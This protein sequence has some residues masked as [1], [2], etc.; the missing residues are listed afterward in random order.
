MGEGVKGSTSADRAS[1]GRGGH[2][3]HGVYSVFYLCDSQCPV[4]T[5]DGMQCWYG[6]ELRV[7]DLPCCPGVDLHHGDVLL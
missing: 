1:R 3:G 5:C 4:L 2:G 7:T 6:D